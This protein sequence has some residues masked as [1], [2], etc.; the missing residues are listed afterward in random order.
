MGQVTVPPPP[1][2]GGR[3]GWTKGWG[4]VSASGFLVIGSYTKKSR[5]VDFCQAMAD[6]EVAVHVVEIE[7]Q[8]DLVDVTA[9]TKSKGCTRDERGGGGTPASGNRERCKQVGITPCAPHCRHLVS[10]TD[11]YLGPG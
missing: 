2:G 10:Q 3:G 11:L 1:E 4:V 7:E 6:V 8:C 5:E 9:S